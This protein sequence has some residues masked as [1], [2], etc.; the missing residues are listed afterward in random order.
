VRL[1]RAA[2]R[3]SRPIFS[4]DLVSSPTTSCPTC[5]QAIKEQLINGRIYEN[6]EKLVDKNS[7]FEKSFYDTILNHYEVNTMIS[8]LAKF[9]ITT[10]RVFQ[11]EN[12]IINV[13]RITVSSMLKPLVHFIRVPDAIDVCFTGKENVKPSS[14]C[15]P[16]G[17]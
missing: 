1:T 8:G 12:N 16:G 17:G 2:T 11:T 9:N 5:K 3:I 14:L 7:L 13:T 15:L 10:K 4:K 6:K